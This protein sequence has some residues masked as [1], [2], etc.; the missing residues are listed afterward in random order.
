MLRIMSEQTLVIDEELCACFLDWKN[1]CNRVNWKKYLQILEGPGID[2]S[3]RRLVRKV[4]IDQRVKLRL[5]QEET[6]SMK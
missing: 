4:C 1:A 3:K 5:D 2:W 6:R